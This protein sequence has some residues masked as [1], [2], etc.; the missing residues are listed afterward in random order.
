MGTSSTP[1]RHDM[2]GKRAVDVTQLTV[3]F[4]KDW[5][6]RIDALAAKLA[7]PGLDFTRTDT[8]RVIVARGLAVLEQEQALPKDSK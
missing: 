7:P 6:D 1:I 3:R 8:L 5:L 4:Q 2:P